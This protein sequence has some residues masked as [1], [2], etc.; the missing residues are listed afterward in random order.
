VDDPVGEAALGPVGVVDGR[1]D[2]GR[3]PHG[4]QLEEH[5][6]GPSDVEQEVVDQSDPRLG[7]WA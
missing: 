1:E 6:L 2:V 3:R 5:A 4:T 7:R